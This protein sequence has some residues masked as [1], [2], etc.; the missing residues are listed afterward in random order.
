VLAAF[1]IAS[2]VGGGA[3]SRLLPIV[4]LS[5]GLWAL[6][7]VDDRRT[8][9]PSLRLAVEAAAAAVLWDAGLGWHIFDRGLAVSPERVVQL[10]E[11]SCGR[12]AAEGAVVA[13]EVVAP[14]EAA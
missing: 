1:L 10:G 5:V 12:L 11:P 4:A 6:G 14:E 3:V 7:T 8:L 2:L 13:P 9:Q